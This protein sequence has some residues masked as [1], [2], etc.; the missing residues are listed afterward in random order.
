MNDVDD[1]IAWTIAVWS[2]SSSHLK[3]SKKTEK[4]IIATRSSSS[5]NSRV[6]HVHKVSKSFTTHSHSTG[7][8]H[9]MKLS[10]LIA[11]HIPVPDHIRIYDEAI[12]MMMIQ[13]RN[14]Q[15]WWRPI[16][17]MAMEP[18]KIQNQVVNLIMG[19]DLLHMHAYMLLRIIILYSFHLYWEFSYFF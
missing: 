4:Y 16:M 18:L 5:C 13:S 3:T 1:W 10:L 11:K 17:V 6:E 14:I 8:W 2:L 12:P 7:F 15:W 9:G 19:L